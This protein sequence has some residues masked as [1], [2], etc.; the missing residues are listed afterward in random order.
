MVDIIYT[1][2]YIPSLLWSYSNY[3][4]PPQYVL[5]P[6][7]RM[8]LWIW[9]HQ[10]A[11]AQFDDKTWHSQTI[12][13]GRSINFR[14]KCARLCQ[15]IWCWFSIESKQEKVMISEVSARFTVLSSV[16]LILSRKIN[17]WCKL[18][19]IWPKIQE[20]SNLPF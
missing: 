12:Y 20:A 4:R 10:M 16:N 2:S 8:L 15:R 17:N 1:Y 13:M 9:R 18:T 14:R 3:L 11:L 7:L 19:Y 6:S 5:Y